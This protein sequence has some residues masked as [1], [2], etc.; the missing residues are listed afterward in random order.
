[1]EFLK[2]AYLMMFLANFFHK[3]AAN[4]CE[5]MSEL[6][7][8][9]KGPMFGTKRDHGWIKAHKIWPMFWT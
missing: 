3:I 7:P 2:I 6:R 4:V 1:M 5:K 8:N 9:T